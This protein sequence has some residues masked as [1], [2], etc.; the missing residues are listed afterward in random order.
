MKCP[1]FYF[2]CFFNN[3]NFFFFIAKILQFFFWGDRYGLQAGHSTQLMTTRLYFCSEVHVNF[4][5]EKI[6]ELKNTKIKTKFKILLFF[7]WDIYFLLLFHFSRS[8][9]HFST[10]QYFEILA[11]GWV[12]FCFEIRG[13]IWCTSMLG[14]RAM[15]QPTLPSIIYAIFSLS[16]CIS[17][18]QNK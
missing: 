14:G 2:S 9:S 7:K 18:Q 15:E 1:I 4:P 17:I 3:H 12:H 8:H 5:P 10:Y 6:H 13:K 11:S 16:C